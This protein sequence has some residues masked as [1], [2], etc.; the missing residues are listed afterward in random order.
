M[1]HFMNRLAPGFIDRS[2]RA[3]LTLGIIIPLVL[4]LG[5]FTV[6]EYTRDRSNLLNNLSVVASYNGRLIK[7]ALWHSMLTSN[8]E[9]VQRTLI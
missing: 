1:K 7:D 5:A 9:N 6:I 4:I 2:L 3:K 8:F